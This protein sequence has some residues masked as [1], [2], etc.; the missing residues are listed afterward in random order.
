[1]L[2]CLES[3]K[4]IDHQD[5]RDELLRKRHKDTFEWLLDDYRYR[6][7]LNDRALTVLWINGAPGCGKSVL[8]S[9][10]SE[11]LAADSGIGRRVPVV[12]YFF[13]R[14]DNDYLQTEVAIFQNL[15]AQL[16]DQ[17]P[18]LFRH[19]VSEYGS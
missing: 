10:L 1:M 6:K 12:A 4:P 14:H 8:S 19:F 18:R 16:L 2:A 15:L 7:W 11:R 9:F 13:C 17:T 5:Y 3:L